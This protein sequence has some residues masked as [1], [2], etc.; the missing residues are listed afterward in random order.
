M[1]LSFV[2]L[3]HRAPA[4]KAK[5]GRGNDYLSLFLLYITNQSL[6]LHF[7]TLV[8]MVWFHPY[9]LST[10]SQAQCW[11]WG[12][13]I[14]ISDIHSLQSCKVGNSDKPVI[15][16][17]STNL[18]LVADLTVLLMGGFCAIQL[19]LSPQLN[20]Q[21]VPFRLQLQD[22]WGHASGRRECKRELSLGF[23][24]PVSFEEEQIGI[25]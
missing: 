20:H 14:Q 3:I 6:R 10:L 18:S 13:R 23:W 16:P 22:S 12:S 17:K 15:F 21:M 24:H 9:W 11:C 1:N 4:K 8:S 7:S 5:M 2:S 25:C 19:H